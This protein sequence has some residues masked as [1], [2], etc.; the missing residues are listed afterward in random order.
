MIVVMTRTSPARP[1]NRPIARDPC[2]HGID[3]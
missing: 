3:F 1:A 2:R